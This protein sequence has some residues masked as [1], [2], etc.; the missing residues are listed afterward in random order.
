MLQVAKYQEEWA[1]V[2]S[3]NRH[4][5]IDTDALETQ[6]EQCADSSL[7]SV[8]LAN[9]ETGVIQPLAEIVSAAKAYGALDQL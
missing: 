1:S 5:I 4:G 9:N 2:L 7:V 6:L 8:M 3:V